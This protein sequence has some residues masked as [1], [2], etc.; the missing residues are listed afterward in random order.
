MFGPP[1]IAAVGMLVDGSFAGYCSAMKTTVSTRMAMLVGAAVLLITPIVAA[2]DARPP[3]VQ[4]LGSGSV[5]L[6]YL[7]GGV[8][9][10]AAVG[11][12]IMPSGRE[13]QD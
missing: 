10:L 12:A 9:A 13:H 2:Q 7:I 8:L 5:I 1:R 3:A 6:P 4:D 11:L